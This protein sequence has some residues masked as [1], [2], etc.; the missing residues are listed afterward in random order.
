M[1]KKRLAVVAG[2]WHFPLHFYEQ[3]K[4]QEIPVGWEV[5]LFCVSHRNPDLDIIK[6]EKDE[7]LYKLDDMKSELDLSNVQRMDVKFYS[8]L[9]TLEEI[10]N[11]GW[12]Y[13]EELNTIG[14][15]GITNQWLDK[16]DYRDY[17]ILLFTHDD[18]FIFNNKLFTTA[19]FQFNWDDWLV[20]TNG[21][22]VGPDVYPVRGSFD[23]FKKEMLVMI[24]GKFDLSASTMTRIGKVDTPIDKIEIG[25]W[26]Y[27]VRK[28]GEFIKDNNLNEKIKNL[29]NTYRIST[30][31]F[32]GERGYLSNGG[33]DTMSK[34]VKFINDNIDMENI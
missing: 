28:F 24:G 4:N 31:C 12:N 9:A 8:R 10:K 6:L 32:E 1:N 29:S 2:G 3:I 15:W 20:I 5:D 17:D 30:F 21:I 18:N 33:D 23:F 16:N 26:N 34:I 7:Y 14:D 25:D 13:V 19:I 27:T 22:N 11:L